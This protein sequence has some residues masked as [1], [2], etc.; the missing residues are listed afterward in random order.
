MAF[1]TGSVNFSKGEIAEELVARI[2]VGSYQSAVKTARNV[3]VRKYGGLAKRPGT[4]FVAEVFNSN[5]PVRLLPFQ[6]SIQQA[7]VLE[8]GQ[9]YMRVAA[10][11]GMVVGDDQAITGITQ[12]AQAVVTSTAHGCI[13]NDTVFFSGVQGMVEINGRVAN[14]VAVVDANHFRIDIDTSGFSAFLGE[15][16]PDPPAPPSHRGRTRGRGTF[17]I[18][19]HL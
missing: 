15:D 9:S 5:Y 11:G 6:Y 14:V 3:V 13:V 4:R 10:V 12:E 17:G 1:R 18:G 16:T 19:L 2:D 7:F 8:M